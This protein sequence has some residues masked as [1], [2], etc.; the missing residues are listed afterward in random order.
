MHGQCLYPSS[1]QRTQIQREEELQSGGH[2]TKPTVFVIDADASICQS[3]E[4]IIRSA[5]QAVLIFASAAAFLACPRVLGP[6]CLVLNSVLPDSCGL[7][8]QER[9]K[10][11]LGL[12][13]ILIAGRSD[14]PTAVRAMKAGAVEVLTKPIDCNALLDAIDL[15]IGRSRAALDQHAVTAALVSDY[16]S[17]SK[18]EREV[19]ELVVSGLLNKQAAH[20]LGISE[21]T[22]KAHRG[23][24]MRKMNART[25]ADLV[26]KATH[27]SQGGPEARA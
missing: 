1:A 9:L 23:Q 25:F 13:V 10:G 4:C 2:E 27:L 3:L 5:G 18:R 8:L 16:A 21:I 6:S 14:V 11:E 24:V 15:A 17:L 22:V 7:E 12:S 20:Q 26:K 19:M